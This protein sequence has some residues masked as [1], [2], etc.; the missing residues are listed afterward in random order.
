[1]RISRFFLQASTPPS[2][3]ALLVASGVDSR[4]NDDDAIDEAIA[5]SFPASDPPANTVETAV[6]LGPHA[7][8]AAVTDNSSQHRFELEV[9]GRTAVLIYQRKPG[10][11]RLIHT[12]VPVELRGQHLGEA[13]VLAAVAAARR[14]QLGIEASCP[15]ARAYFERHPEALSKL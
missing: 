5:E 15:F 9:G 11:L 4:K 7:L 1:M 2:L 10:T 14:E 13:L 8:I 12:E 6:R 3:H